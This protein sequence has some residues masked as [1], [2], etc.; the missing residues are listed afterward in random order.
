[1]VVSWRFG[2]ISC[3][4]VNPLSAAAGGR[5]VEEVLEQV[6]A[7]FGHDRFGVELHAFNIEF[8]MADTH[9]D[10]VFGSCSYFEG[11]GNGVGFDCERVV[12]HRLERLRK[13]GENALASD[14]KSVV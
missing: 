9:D 7:G 10:A 12:S 3:P 4:Q 6:F 5:L 14:R 11:V 1:M 13:S 8:L 2:L